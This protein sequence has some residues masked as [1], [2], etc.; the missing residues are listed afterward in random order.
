MAYGDISGRATV[1]PYAPSAWGVCDSCGEWSNR[2][3][4]KM[5]YEY[6]GDDLVDTGFR[7][8]DRCL[9]KPQAQFLT[10]I[11]PLDPVPIDEPRPEVP[12]LLQNL[13][14]F[15]Q[16]VGPQ[17]TSLSNP[18]LTELDPTNPFKTKAELLASAAS[19][20]GLPVPSLTDRSGTISVAS[21]AQQIMAAN[22]ARRYLLLYDPDALFLAAAQNG[23]PSLT[24]PTSTFLGNSLYAPVPPAELGTVTPG[25]GGALL[26]N[27]LTTPPAAVWLGSVFV[28]GFVQGQ[29]FWCFE[30]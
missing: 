28:V 13:N 19:G 17:G 21:V 6:R 15:T 14:G 4:L 23:P 10:P 25:T 22:P 12:V 27:G 30:G 18:I 1:N 29:R 8:C 24:L 26:Q 11:L 5:Q 7:V 3:D 9:S 2:V 20:W 16:S